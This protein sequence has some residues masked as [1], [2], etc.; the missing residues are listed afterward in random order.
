MST[1]LDSL[2]AQYASGAK[3]RQQRDIL[4]FLRDMRQASFSR[5]QIART[6]NIPVGSVCARVDELLAEGLIVRAD[7]VK[8]SITNRTVQTVKAAPDLFAA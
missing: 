8:D 5:A 3:Q 7:P 1:K 4:N 2:V 6:K